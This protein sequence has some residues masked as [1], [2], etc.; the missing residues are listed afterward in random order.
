[1]LVHLLVNSCRAVR[2]MADPGRDRRRSRSPRCAVE[3]GHHER[4]EDELQPDPALLLKQEGM[5]MSWCGCECPRMRPDKV[6]VALRGRRCPEPSAARLAHSSRPGGTVADAHG[7]RSLPGVPVCRRGVISPGDEACLDCQY[8]P[9][10]GWRLLG[11]WTSAHAGRRTSQCEYRRDVG[12]RSPTRHYQYRGC[13]WD[14][15]A[16]SP[17]RPRHPHQPG[18]ADQ[19]QPLSYPSGSPGRGSRVLRMRPDDRR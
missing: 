8:P 18:P 6:F 13:A 7:Q 1:M 10:R 3:G 16:G 15:A 12:R 9:G 2:E 5:L 17:G 14:G 4:L 19:E 11:M